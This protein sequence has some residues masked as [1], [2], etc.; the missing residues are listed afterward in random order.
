VRVDNV[1]VPLV[2][3]TSCIASADEEYEKELQEDIHE[4]C[5]KIGEV[6]KIT[7]FAKHVDGVVVVKFASSG[8]AARCVDVMNGRFFAG[9]KLECGFWDGTDYTYRESKTEQKQRSEQF[10]EWLEEGSASSDSEGEGEENEEDRSVATAE[11]QDV[12]AGR[13]IPPLGDDS[14]DSDVESNG[15]D[16]TNPAAGDEVHAGRVMPDLDDLDD[17]E[18]DT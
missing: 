14:D 5:S 2:K 1:K 9:R 7:L 18:G 12:H 13:E 4:E 16:D 17:D 3:L 10:E 6:S 15:E 8:S 11:A